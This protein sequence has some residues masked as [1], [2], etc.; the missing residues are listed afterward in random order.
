MNSPYYGNSSE[1]KPSNNTLN[2]WLETKKNSIGIKPGLFETVNF[3]NDSSWT[4]IA[5]LIEIGAFTITIFGSIMK[6]NAN[7]EK[8]GLIFAIVAAFLFVAFDIVGVSLNGA[9]RSNK[10]L[11]RAK[12]A[13]T[14]DP[15]ILVRLH[16]TTKAVSFREFSGVVMLFISAFIK[17]GVVALASSISSNAIIIILSMFFLIVIYIHISHTGYYLSARK[18]SKMMRREENVWW[19]EKS[20]GIN[21][22][23]IQP[24]RVVFQSPTKLS[25][26]ES[27]QNGRQKIEFI[28]KVDTNEGYYYSLSLS[29]QG[30]LWDE[31]IVSLLQN[32][33]PMTLLYPSLFKACINLQLTQLNILS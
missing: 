18:C 21:V 16:K 2:K 8:M 17:I 29:S 23:P 28:E 27:F 24:D 4:L 33:D 32:F 15:N 25:N 6:Y 11:A 13:I 20:K 9:E 22:E 1:F 12:I 3:S 19:E 7:Q 31:D 26:N 30:I 5:L 14:N 10:T